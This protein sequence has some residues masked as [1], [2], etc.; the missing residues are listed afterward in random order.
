MEILAKVE[1]GQGEVLEIQLPYD[2]K[3]DMIMNLKLPCRAVIGIIQRRNRVIIPHGRTQLMPFDSVIVF[4][5]HQNADA[6]LH[7]FKK[8]RQIMNLQ[9]VSST[10]SIILK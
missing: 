5:E 1:R 4:T 6:V 9:A 7:F 3:T 10:L 2:F 8:R